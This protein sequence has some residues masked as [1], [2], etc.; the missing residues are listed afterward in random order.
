MSPSLP[1]RLWLPLAAAALA[2]FGLWR[3]HP[4]QWP[5]DRRLAERGATARGVVTA[6]GPDTEVHYSFEVDGTVYSGVGA[7]GY[8]NPEF[9]ALSDGDDVMVSYMPGKPSD[10][11]LGLASEHLRDQNRAI[12]LG[13]LLF[14]PA[15]LLALRRELARF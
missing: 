2:A 10:S 1:S 6:K 5:R 15:L 9:E 4:Q 14:V 11:M 12:A 3:L 13:L 7:A 8:G